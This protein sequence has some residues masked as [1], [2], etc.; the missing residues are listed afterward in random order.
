MRCIMG[1]K[2]AVLIAFFALLTF[3]PL[4]FAQTAQ[5]SSSTATQDT[6]RKRAKH[7]YTDDDFPFRSSAT[8]AK[9]PNLE[10]FYVVRS[11]LLP[12]PLTLAHIEKL[13]KD[14]AAS[15]SFNRVQTKQ[16]IAKLYLADKDKPFEGRE[17]WENR[18][19]AV[20]KAHVAAL[21]AYEKDVV[22]LKQQ[23]MALLA[24]K[25]PEGDDLVKLHELCQQLIARYKPVAILTRQF[26][27][28]NDEAI[29]K[30]TKAAYGLS[31]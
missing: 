7:V 1:S 3:V 11:Y 24:V 22:F 8:E 20:W 2:S 12:E 25:K 23:N 28:L 16:A 13:Q 17:D 4:E 19:M 30:V 26:Q 27:D 18:M 21:E 31:R 6:G 14:F 5:Q 29:S 15:I 10:G 9:E